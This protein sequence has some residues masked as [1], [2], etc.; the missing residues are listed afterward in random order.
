MTITIEIFEKELDVLAAFTKR[1][2]GTPRELW[3]SDRIEE[4][5]DK[6]FTEMPG[7]DPSLSVQI[8]TIDRN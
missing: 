3:L 2:D 1:D 8:T 7:K 5:L 6:M 4:A